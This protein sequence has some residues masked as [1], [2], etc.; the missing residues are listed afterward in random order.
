MKVLLLLL[1]TCNRHRGR[2]HPISPHPHPNTNICVRVRLAVAS[3]SG[4]I[5]RWRRH[6]PPQYTC[7]GIHI[8]TRLCM[9]TH[10]ILLRRRVSSLRLSRTS[11]PSPN[12]IRR[13]II[14]NVCGAVRRQ[15]MGHVRVRMVCPSMSRWRHR[16][17]IRTTMTVAEWRP[18][19]TERIEERRHCRVYVLRHTSIREG[20]EMMVR[21]RGLCPRGG[22]RAGNRDG[23][24]TSR[25]EGVVHCEGRR[26]LHVGVCVRHCHRR[27]F[28][29][30]GVW[31]PR[32]EGAGEIGVEI[33]IEGGERA[34]VWWGVVR[35]QMRSWGKRDRLRV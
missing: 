31:V 20:M 30:V 19:R 5:Q 26:G 33:K 9:C 7:I 2:L 13:Q 10:D 15:V 23:Y 8:P 4:K 6:P 3:P 1:L 14:I 27:V 28:W 32:V 21:T 12:A 11:S 18:I 35:V 17:R 24:S 22:V 16:V 34:N 25:R 29:P